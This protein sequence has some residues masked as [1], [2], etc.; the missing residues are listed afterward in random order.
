LVRQTDALRERWEPAAGTTIGVRDRRLDGV[1]D[2]R[3]SSEVTGVILI[4]SDG[5]VHSDDQ[6]SAQGVVAG[7]ADDPLR[8]LW[9]G[10]AG[11]LTT[12]RQL[13]LGAARARRDG[14]AAR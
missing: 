14:R 11:E 9:V 1:L 6:V 7:E 3:G 10:L 13:E 5:G 12:R 8:V 4:G 2:P